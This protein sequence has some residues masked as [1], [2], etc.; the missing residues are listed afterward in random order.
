MAGSDTARLLS[1]PQ[2][3]G[4]RW[5]WLTAAVIGL[6]VPA[7]SIGF[8]YAGPWGLIAAGVAAIVCW[9]AASLALALAAFVSGPNAALA[10]M[11]LGMAIRMSLPLGMFFWLRQYAELTQ[12]GFVLQLGLFYL[13]MLAVETWLMLP[14]VGALASPPKDSSQDNVS[15]TPPT[16]GSLRTAG[17][18]L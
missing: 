6:L 11:L 13:L 18:I 17:G 10:V 14:D 9:F 5:L 7:G 4:A 15:N 1:R 8:A 16:A 3:W 12:A 2:G